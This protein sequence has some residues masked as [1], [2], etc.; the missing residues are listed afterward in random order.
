MTGEV[1]LQ[2][3]LV[4]GAGQGLGFHIAK[5][6]KLAGYQL[7]VTDRDPIA[8]ENAAMQL[9]ASGETVL[10]LSLDIA[11]KSDFELALEKTIKRFGSLQVLVN[12]ASITRATPVMEISPEEFNEV[13]NVNL[14]GTFFGCQVIG[15]Y[16]AEQ[17]YGRIVN[18]AS[19]A[20]Q[21]GGTSTGAH[22]AASK[23]A[24]ITVTKVF[25][26]EL[27]SKGV[28]VNAVAPGPIESPMVSA[29]VPEERL[30]TL[31]DAIPV[32]EL[33]DADFIG[34]VVVQFARPEAYFTTGTTWDVNGGL[35][36][37]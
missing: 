31:L 14:G 17:G 22:Y 3:A 13:V 20:G 5:S 24:I 18:M 19:L 34:D 12:N 32:G 10:S 21:N 8:A 36:M 35:F 25:A 7:V 33:G 15:A 23:G 6:L 11:N 29:L 37:R 16:F 2:T 27:A 26:K 30:A 28:T 9:D 4:T 1:K